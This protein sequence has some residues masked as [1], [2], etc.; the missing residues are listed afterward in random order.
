MKI[1][2]FGIISSIVLGA[3]SGAQSMEQAPRA[4]TTE[5][6][7]IQAVKE[8]NAKDLAFALAIR[9][10]DLNRVRALLNTVNFNDVRPHPAR[11]PRRRPDA[12]TKVDP[13]RE[14]WKS[15]K[16]NSIAIMQALLDAGANR[17]SLNGILFEAVNEGDLDGVRWLLARGARNPQALEEA[18]SLFETAIPETIRTHE[19]IYNA[20]RDAK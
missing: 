6:D 10:G 5:A 17:E 9:Q 2:K 16:L 1:L 14:A 4:L 20:I 13:V 18:K 12:D 8:Q 3:V 11:D 15:R 7:R 19:E